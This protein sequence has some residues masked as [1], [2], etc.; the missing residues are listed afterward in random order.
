V[1]D[2]RAEALRRGYAPVARAYHEQLGDELA[3]KPLDCALLDV[4]AR[5]VGSGAPVC[6]AGCG[7]GHVAR[8]L[9]DRGVAV[10]GV[11]LSPAMVAE[12]T[13]RHP[14]ISFRVGNLTDLGGETDPFA[15]V[16]AFYSLIHLSREAVA[17]ALVRIR[18]RLRPRG[19]LFVAF[20]VRSETLHLD[21]WWGRPVSIDFTFFE[22]DEMRS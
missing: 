14:D 16:L 4:F 12:A 1:N 11:D 3:G 8:Y 18:E 19:L 5:R 21:E 7:P 6:D 17:G 13:R 10:E 9:R 22:V 20:H 2:P 15:A